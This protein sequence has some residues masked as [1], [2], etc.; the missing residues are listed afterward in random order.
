MKTVL[1]HNKYAQEEGVLILNADYIVSI[2]PYNLSDDKKGSVIITPYNQYI[3]KETY[4]EIL[5]LIA[6]VTMNYVN[7]QNI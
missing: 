5:S 7:D 6:I 3:V 4:H 2:E 1:V